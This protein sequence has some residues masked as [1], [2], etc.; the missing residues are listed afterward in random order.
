VTARQPTNPVRIGRKAQT[1]STARAFGCAN[2]TAAQATA[3]G[4]TSSPY[5]TGVGAAFRFSGPTATLDP[6]K[7]DTLLYSSI[8]SG[9]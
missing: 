5:A 4:A 8:G 1:G 6:F 3:R 9:G 2:H 7:P